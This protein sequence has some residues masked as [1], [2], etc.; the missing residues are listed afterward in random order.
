MNIVIVSSEASLWKPLFVQR[1]IEGLPPEQKVAAVVL[2]P[3][4]PPKVGKRKHLIRYATM[5]GPWVFLRMA[6]RESFHKGLDIL[7]R[8]IPFKGVH[9]IAGV[10]RRHAIPVLHSTDVNDQDT[11]DFMGSFAP[12][13]LLSSGNQIFGKDVLALP[14]KACLNRHTSLLPAY[15]GIY[16]VFW[17]LLNGEKEVGVSVHTMTER[18]DG[19]EVVAQASLPIRPGDTFFS[20]FEACFAL[21]VDV[22]LEAVHRIDAGDWEPIVNER[23]PSYYS[24]PTRA[25]VREFR[26]KGLKML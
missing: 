22:V 7:S 8:V 4:K 11:I 21:S 20:L 10:C 13:I 25:D 16:P 1:I 9:S 6:V 26:R 15:S 5:L 3:F 2:T 12:D 24:Y 14:A 18:I 23:K 17:C 19:G